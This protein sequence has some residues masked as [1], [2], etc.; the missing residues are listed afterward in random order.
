MTS[1]FKLETLPN[2][3]AGASRIEADLEGATLDLQ[4]TGFGLLNYSWQDVVMREDGRFWADTNRDHPMSGTFYDSD[5]EGVAGRFSLEIGSGAE[6]S[7]AHGV[8]G[9]L[10]E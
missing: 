3:V 1:G 2:P 7:S 8:F 9:A 6:R 5:H 4:L 10:R